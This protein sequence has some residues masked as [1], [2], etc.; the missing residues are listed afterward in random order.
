MPSFSSMMTAKPLLTLLCV[1]ER[2][3]VSLGKHV[4]A[5]GLV[6]FMEDRNTHSSEFTRTGLP[7]LETGLQLLLKAP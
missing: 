1:S 7:K 6:V 3:R 2:M 4:Q 5:S